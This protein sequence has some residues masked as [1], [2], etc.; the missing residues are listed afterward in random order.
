V[1]IEKLLINNINR[2]RGKGPLFILLFLM[3]YLMMV[4]EPSHANNVIFKV[5]S[6]VSFTTSQDVGIV[7]QEKSLNQ[8]FTEKYPYKI[9]KFIADPV[10]A[11]PP[12]FSNIFYMEISSVESVQPLLADLIKDASIVWAESNYSFPIHFVPNDSLYPYQWALHTLEMESAWDI[13]LGISDIIVGVID[14]GIDYLHEDLQNQLWINHPEDLNGNGIL[15]PGDINGTDDDLNGYIDDVIGWDFTHAPAFPDGGDYLDPDNDPMDDY[16]GGHGTPVGGLIAARTNNIT[17]ISGVA[18]G[19]KIMVLRAGT[20]GGYLEQDDVAEA[21]LYAVQNGCKIINMSFGDIVFSHLLKE[22][23]DYGT[24]QG[25]LFVASAGNSGTDILQYPAAYDNTISVGATDINNNIAGF[26]NYGSKIDLVAPGQNIKSTGTQNYYGQYSGTS[27]A[28][29]LVC[30]ILGLLWSQQPGASPQQITSQLLNA[31]TD[32]GATGWDPY[33]GH[34]LLNG[35][36]TLSIPASSI[37]RINQPQTQSGVHASKVPIIGTAAGGQF[38]RYSLAFGVGINPLH[39][40]NFKENSSQVVSDT[41][42]F[43]NTESLQD[44]TYTL[45]LTVT[46]RDR[47]TTVMRIVLSLDRTPPMVRDF[48]MIPVII[49]DYYGYLI[50]LTVDDQSTATLHYRSKGSPVFNQ[51]LLSNYISEYHYFVISQKMFSGEMEFYISLE[52]IARLESNYDNNG[53]YFN[54]NLNISTALSPL[55]EEVDEI[56]GSAYLFGKSHDFNGDAVNDVLGNMKLNFQNETLIRAINYTSQNFTIHSGTIPA[57]ARDFFDIDNDG[58]KDLLAGYGS[59]SY[60]FEGNSL[61]DFSQ[62]PRQFTIIDFWAARISNLNSDQYPEIIALHQN[63]WHIFRL[64]DPNSLSL[65]LLQVLENPTDGENRYGVPFAELADLNNNGKPDILIGDYDGDLILYENS[66]GSQFSPIASIRLEGEDATH[67]YATGDFD[68]DSKTE[69]AVAT[70]KLA[71]SNGEFSALGQYWVFNIL[72]LDDNGN[73]KIIW[74]QNFHLV[75]Q[76]QDTQAGITT[77]DYNADG[78]P[79]IL[80]TPFPRAYFIQFWNN[81]YRVRW[82]NAGINSNAAPPLNA[83]QFLLVKDSSLAV[84]EYQETPQKPAAPAQLWAESADSSHIQIGWTEVPGA[85]FYLILREDLI[86]G[87]S[88]TVLTMNSFYRDTLVSSGHKYSFGIQTIDSS[89]TFPVSPLSQILGIIAENTPEVQIVQV[90]GRKQLLVEFDKPLS[91]QSYDVSRYY[92]IPDSIYPNTTVRGKGN[93]QILL[94]FMDNLNIGNHQI[95]MHNLYNISNVPFYRD[96]IIIPFTVSG[97]IKKPYIKKIS[98]ISKKEIFIEFSQPMEK[99]SVEE[100]SN[101]LLTPDDRVIEAKLALGSQAGIALYLT[102]KNRMGSLGYDYYLEVIGVRDI[103]GNQISDDGTNRLLIQNT[104]SNLDEL[105]VFP[106]PFRASS[107]LPLLHF[108]NVPY[109]CE[110]IIYSAN[111]E[112]IKRIKNSQ[113]NGGVTWDLTNERGEQVNNGI[114]LYVALYGDQKK[115]DKFMIIK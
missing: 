42:G 79:D 96:S 8:F 100:V 29:P 16:P 1:N 46:N 62:A 21:I 111:G 40:D 90:S 110:I 56:S 67:R 77:S 3:F 69:I 33:Y 44:T 26:S 104:I 92:L 17:G 106:N 97:E 86:T 24:S 81:E 105:I 47:S 27:F 43:W 113:Y 22:A 5:K 89:Y 83:N 70:Q 75:S 36:R 108:G 115:L 14:T 112:R 13:Q 103:W 41:L 50:S 28:A 53:E 91:E 54:L 61:P 4:I 57:F 11:P 38:S 55:F 101:Y 87:S 12:S 31:C 68:G 71:D 102:G 82:Y 78:R 10:Q 52:N 94:G 80:F 85:Q 7:F 59:K 66:G 84:F 88:D 20:S 30:G 32:F 23:V 65:S 76:H 18:P 114:Y 34:G 51:K 9:K 72:K 19:I 49:E 2:V 95:L 99:N 107:S 64:D 58:Y 98:M 37:A 93:H 25:V 15:D 60:I 74:Q 73:F 39:F 109:G 48:Q 6:E 63:Q 45:Q 35:N